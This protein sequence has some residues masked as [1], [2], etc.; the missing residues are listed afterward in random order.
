MHIFLCYSS[1]DKL[2]ARTLYNR[3]SVYIWLRTW[4]EFG[5]HQNI[6]E[7]VENANVVILFLSKE[8]VFRRGF[9]EEIYTRTIEQIKAKEK[10]R[11]V[12][13]A[14][15]RSQF[16]VIPIRLNECSI[17]E[18]LQFLSWKDSFIA[19]THEEIINS[20][21]SLW[22]RPAVYAI[23]GNVTAKESSQLLAE[24]PAEFYENLDWCGYV[25]IPVS[26]ETNYSFIIRK[27]QVT[28]EQYFQF[29]QSDDYTD[30]RFW[31]NFPKYDHNCKYIGDWGNSGFDWLNQALKAY[32]SLLEK[33][34]DWKWCF[35]S[36][37]VFSYD[38]RQPNHPAMRITW[39]EANAYCKWLSA[40]WREIPEAT[41]L[42]DLIETNKNLNFRLPLETEIHTALSYDN[43]TRVKVDPT[44][45]QPI[46]N[47]G[48]PPGIP[49]DFSEKDM[50][51]N[52]YGENLKD[53]LTYC[54]GEFF[55]DKV[56]R[57]N[58]RLWDRMSF[59]PQVDYEEYAFRVVITESQ[60]T[61]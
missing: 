11:K 7:V 58:Y 22:K 59:S 18:H 10:R 57:E 4:F 50:L 52:L 30:K 3:L 41:G 55:I 26:K 5:T 6:E 13:A 15:R 45:R 14:E 60:K 20:L 23:E 9:E 33:R 51:A 40:H 24:K 56:S 16:I 48:I 31:I 39:F 47:P 42:S 21:V 27:F 32:P 46:N 43:G 36:I 29:L 8:S 44:G 61:Q 35:P 12:N 19:N 37:S 1:Q 34:R 25:R 28:N 53:S 54:W 49:I 38:F 17:P 2:A